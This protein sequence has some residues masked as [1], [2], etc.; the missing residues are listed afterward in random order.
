VVFGDFKDEIFDHSMVWL[1][2]VDGLGNEQAG[3]SLRFIAKVALL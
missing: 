1:G 3:C 2:Y